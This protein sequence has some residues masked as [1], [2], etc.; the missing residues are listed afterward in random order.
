M[1]DIE[2]IPE[3]EINIIPSDLKIPST[4]YHNKPPWHG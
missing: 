1:Y 3:N 4:W 2:I